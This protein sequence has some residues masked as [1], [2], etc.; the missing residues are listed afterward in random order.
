[1]AKRSSLYEPIL[2]FARV[3]DG[4][5]VTVVVEYHPQHIEHF[6]SAVLANKTGQVKAGPFRFRVV[7]K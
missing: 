2:W 7:P 6:A 1:M 4:K 5:P 3:Q